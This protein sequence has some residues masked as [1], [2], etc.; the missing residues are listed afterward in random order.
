LMHGGHVHFFRAG[1]T[2][3]KKQCSRGSLFA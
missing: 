3:Y 1:I 2:H